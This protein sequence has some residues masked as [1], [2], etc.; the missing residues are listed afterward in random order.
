MKTVIL[1]YLKERSGGDGKTSLT[2][3]L[4]VSKSSILKE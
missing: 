4:M 2:L 1:S 3:T